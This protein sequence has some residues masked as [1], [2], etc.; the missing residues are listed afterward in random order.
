ML[1]LDSSSPGPCGVPVDRL[2]FLRGTAPGHD[3]RYR[4]PACRL[5]RQLKLDVRIWFSRDARAALSSRLPMA[6]PRVDRPDRPG[7]QFSILIGHL[8]IEQPP[9]IHAG[10][11][12]V[13]S[14]GHA[15]SVPERSRRASSFAG[16]GRPA[17]AR[18]RVRPASPARPVRHL[19]GPRYQVQSYSAV[20]PVH[21]PCLQP[22]CP[23]P[24]LLVAQA[25]IAQVRQLL[26]PRAQT[27]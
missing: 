3:P 25:R 2:Q 19:A 14:V 7:L 15:R 23:P 17:A 22:W 5:P 20:C 26:V 21:A 12:E 13:A 16:N 4:F 11:E 27:A 9:V 1:A 8:R 24:E 10:V 6:W 18:P